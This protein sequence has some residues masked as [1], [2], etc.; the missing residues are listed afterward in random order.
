MLLGSFAKEN[1]LYSTFAEDGIGDLNVA[2]KLKVKSEGQPS[3]VGF[4]CG[5]LHIVKAGQPKKHR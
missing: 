1:K 3:A 5:L 4:S 2:L